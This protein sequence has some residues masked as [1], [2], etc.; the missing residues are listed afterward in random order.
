MRKIGKHM[1]TWISMV[2]FVRNWRHFSKRVGSVNV[3]SLRLWHESLLQ[4]FEVGHLEISQRRVARGLPPLSESNRQKWSSCVASR[5]TCAAEPQRKS[6]PNLSV[7]L[8]YYSLMSEDQLNFNQ[9][10][11]L[12]ISSHLLMSTQ[13]TQIR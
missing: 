11:G 7:C 10:V 3:A 5:T 2:L 6:G 4:V 8:C 12:G 9:K 13:I 1:V